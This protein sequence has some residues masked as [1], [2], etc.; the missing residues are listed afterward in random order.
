MHA[1]LIQ[2]PCLRTAG[3]QSA[4]PYV[5]QSRDHKSELYLA[6]DDAAVGVGVGGAFGDDHER[7]LTVEVAAERLLPGHQPGEAGCAAFPGH[8][9]LIRKRA[10]RMP[11]P[12]VL[13]CDE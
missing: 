1:R 4:L 7:T 3:G 13:D 5:I 11:R 12:L 8:D 10:D 2:R 6:G 9:P